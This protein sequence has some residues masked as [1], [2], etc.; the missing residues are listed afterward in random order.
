MACY[1]CWGSK[2]GFATR[3]RTTLICDSVIDSL[4]CDFNRDCKL[5]LAIACHTR[6]GDY[7]IES[8]V[9]YNDG[10]Q[11]QNPKLTKL[12]TNGTHLMWA[13]DIRHIYDRKIGRRMNRRSSH[14]I[15]PP[16][17]VGSRSK[18]KFPR[19]R[20]WG[21]RSARPRE[22]GRWVHRSGDRSMRINSCWGRKTVACSTSPCSNPTTGTVTLFWT[23]LKSR[24]V[25]ENSE[26]FQSFWK[27][28]HQATPR[29][30]CPH[31]G[32]PDSLLSGSH[33][34]KRYFNH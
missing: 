32:D 16:P 2:T 21:F 15:S 12:P 20:N 18:L 8:R 14:G 5:D 11:F 13:A 4:A 22:R 27:S 6:H 23:E 33:R 24:C 1:I 26:L 30:S 28:F 3:H 7:R 19:K 17:A 31:W 29:E 9:F 10:D 34:D 25:A